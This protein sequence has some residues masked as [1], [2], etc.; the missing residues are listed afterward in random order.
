MSTSSERPPE[1]DARISDPEAKKA[2]RLPAAVRALVALAVCCGAVYWAWLEV[3]KSQNPV[4]AAA[5]GLHSWDAAKRLAAVQEVSELGLRNTKEAIPPLI[6]ALGDSDAKVRAAAARSLSVMSSYSVRA[7]GDVNLARSVA[8][9]LVAALDDAAPSVRV[10]AVRG[11]INLTFG[12]SVSRKGGGRKGASAA[13]T[14]PID[15]KKLSGIVVGKFDDPDA[16]VRLEAMRGLGALAPSL[17]GDPPK[18]LFV[19]ME[20]GPAASRAVAIT[21]L[22]RFK[23]GLDPIVPG[24]T[25]MLEKD[26]SAEVREACAHALGQIQGSA[27]T[28][29][30]VPDLVAA[31]RSPDANARFQLVSLLARLDQAAR[32]AAIPAFIAALKEPVD[33]DRP[34]PGGPMRSFTGPVFVA[35]AAL[36]KS[37]PGTPSAKEVITTLTLLVQSGQSPRAAAAARALGQFGKEA[38][39]AIPAVAKALNATLPSKE[40]NRD[41]AALAETLSKIGIETASASEAA[42]ALVEALG[43]QSD[44]TREAAIKALSDLGAKH[45][46]VA[47]P[48]IRALEKNDPS[49]KVRSAAKSFLEA[50][51]GGS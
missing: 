39:T 41:G 33:T 1:S 20:N 34:A 2:G 31:L 7:S 19:A 24:L 17:A 4:L 44:L 18:T 13:D 46:A 12:G 11:L 5:R 30:A 38:D 3:W 47:T 49:D 25:R 26:E 50:T 10:E 28:A 29:A 22:S 43:A 32:R 8:D 27:L 23:Q 51:K 45:A 9:A 42:S 48:Q 16:E 35:A 15:L 36:G 40:Q 37:A 14:A 6:Q 21:T